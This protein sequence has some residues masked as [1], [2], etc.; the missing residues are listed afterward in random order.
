[1]FSTDSII[2]RNPL[3]NKRSFYFVQFISHLL[4]KEN[5]CYIMLKII[6]ESP[7]FSHKKIHHQRILGKDFLIVLLAICRG[8]CN[9][10]NYSHT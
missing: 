7:L 1:M 2:P 8:K 5:S 6:T 3:P 4:R 10:I 9:T